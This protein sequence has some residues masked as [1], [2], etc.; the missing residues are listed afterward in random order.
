MQCNKFQFLNIEIA[1][2]RNKHLYK[3]FYALI[4][5]RELFRP[6]F[7]V[8]YFHK[9]VHLYSLSQ[10]SKLKSQQ[11]PKRHQWV[12]KQT[13]K[14]IQRLLVFIEVGISIKISILCHNVCYERNI[15]IVSFENNNKNARGIVNIEYGQEQS[16]Y[17]AIV[18]QWIKLPRE[19]RSETASR[20]TTDKINI[21]NNENLKVSSL[22][23]RHNLKSNDKLFHNIPIHKFQYLSAHVNHQESP[24]PQ[25]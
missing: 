7:P 25:K 22:Q 23:A 9:L 18:I 17:Y 8:L 3:Q 12:I 24:T 10:G 5:K 6:K 13:N 16:K 21:H 15:V 14:K 2:N 20:L 19:Q 1:I 4:C 11:Q